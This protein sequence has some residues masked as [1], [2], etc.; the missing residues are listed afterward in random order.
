MVVLKVATSL[1]IAAV[2]WCGGIHATQADDY[3]NRPIRLIVPA[4][5]GGISDILSRIL[6]DNLNRILG[7][8]LIVENHGAAGGNLGAGMVAKSAPDGYTLGLIQVGNLAI[9]PHLYKNL[10]FDPL[11][12]LLPVAPVASSPQ[13]V[14]AY[15]GM[16]ANNLTELIALAKR[17]PGKLS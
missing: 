9:N 17:E 11:R 12:D 13:I 15:A 1:A 14:T 5:P 7:Q 10:T 6:S 16:P 4:A 8:S 3:P 2:L